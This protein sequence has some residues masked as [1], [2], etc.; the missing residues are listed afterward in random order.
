MPAWSQSNIINYIF[1]GLVKVS[2]FNANR[3]RVCFVG[4]VHNRFAADRFVGLR[5]SRD[6]KVAGSH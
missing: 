2:R 1:V 6:R 4:E 5:E 3:A